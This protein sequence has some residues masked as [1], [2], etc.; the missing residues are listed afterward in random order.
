MPHESDDFDVVI[1]GGGI[2][3]VGVAQAA[4]ACGHRVLL[5]EQTALAAGTSS[6]SSKL[7]HGGLRYLEQGRIW[8]VRECLRERT[9]LLR[10]A[11]KLVRLQTLNLPIYRA[12]RRRPGKVRLGL[13]LYA[14][15]DGLHADTRFERLRR[16]EW[17]DLDGLVTRDLDAVF[18]FQDAQTDDTKLTAAVM[19]SAQSLGAQLS[20]PATFLGARIT[21]QGCEIDYR[22]KEGELSCRSA[23]VVNAAGPWAPRVQSMI[24]PAPPPRPVELVQGAHILL[25]GPLKKGV[26]Y[27]ESPADGRAVFIMPWGDRTLVGTTE[28]PFQ[29]DPTEVAPLPEEE[30]YLAEVVDHYFPHF[31]ATRP[32]AIVSSWAGLRVLPAGDG[33]A[34]DRSRETI[35]DVDDPRRPR[36]LT[37]YGGKLTTYRATA[38]KVMRRLAPSLPARAPVADTRTLPLVPA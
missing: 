24:D 37:L 21:S 20:M 36:V 17:D 7:I 16:R 15:L 25:G 23:V 14:L 28:T 18:R 11:P 3:G 35:F 2:H 8:M 31:Q 10:L 27:L 34:F 13:S 33:R 5:L 4:A 29:G 19:R 6:R 12:T 9:H 38:E 30:Q 22:P 26:Y 32:G 1:I